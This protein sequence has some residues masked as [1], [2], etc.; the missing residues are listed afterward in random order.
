MRD[1][2]IHQRACDDCGVQWM[3]TNKG[4]GNKNGTLCKECREKRKMVACGKCQTRFVP[5]G[6]AGRFCSLK[7]ANEAQKGIRN[8][9]LWCGDE[10][11]MHNSHCCNEHRYSR[12]NFMRWVSNKATRCARLRKSNWMNKC[13]A[14]ANNPK[15][16]PQSNSIDKQWKERCRSAAAINRHRSAVA[17]CA[18][19]RQANASRQRGKT[20]EQVCKTWSNEPRQAGRWRQK[21]N[22]TASNQLKRL[23]R[24]HNQQASQD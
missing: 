2:C 18:E 12:M 23:R 16:Q 5:K 15:V 9:C 22:N 3:S 19:P 21:C 20:W 13:H 17:I 8:N 11:K 14:I 7:C 10:C 24:K 6:K 1:R 4:V